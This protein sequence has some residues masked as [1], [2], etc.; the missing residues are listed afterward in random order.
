MLLKDDEYW[1]EMALSLAARAGDIDE[2]PVG[3]I[4]VRNNEI[5]GEGFNQTL[6][7]NDPTAHAEMMAL[8]D[9]AQ[10]VKNYR[11]VDASLYVT[12]EPC[13]MCAGALI[14]ARI[15]RLVYGAK[16]LRAGAIESSIRV[17]D[18]PSLNHKLEVRSGVCEDAAGKLMSTFFQSKRKNRP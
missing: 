11:L 4:I 2:V 7:L 13:T 1:M 12:I 14:H 10:R 5:I 3:A 6:N 18:N 16:E 17:L 8:R 15:K 9:A